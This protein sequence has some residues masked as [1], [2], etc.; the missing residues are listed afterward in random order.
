[1]TQGYKNGMEGEVVHSIP[2]ECV[3]N[4]PIKQ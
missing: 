4:L 1:M 3:C 2:M